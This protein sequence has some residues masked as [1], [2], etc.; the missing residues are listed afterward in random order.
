MTT[1]DDIRSLYRSGDTK[2]LVE[3]VSRQWRA[4]N[5]SLSAELVELAALAA[6]KEAQWPQAHE[7]LAWLCHQRDAARDAYH[8]GLVLDKLGRPAEAIAAFEKSAAAAQ[9]RV[10]AGLNMAQCLL[11]TQQAR[12]ALQVLERMPLTNTPQAVPMHTLL[13]AQALYALGRYQ[14]AAECAAAAVKTQPKPPVNVLTVLAAAWLK[15]G[16]VDEAVAIYRDILQ[17]RPNNLQ[18]RYNLAAALSNHT[19]ADALREAIEHA[20]Q[21]LETAPEHAQARHTLALS[22]AKLGEWPRVIEHGRHLLSRW[23]EEPRYI[24]TLATALSNMGQHVQALEVIEAG[25]R[26]CTH[27]PA[28]LYRQKGI[29][30]CRLGQFEQAESA[31]AQ[32]HG[33]DD[34][35]QRTLAYL[36]I[37]RLALGQREKVAEFYGH[38]QLVQ[39]LRLQPSAAFGGLASYHQ[40]L[41]EDIRHHSRL[42]LN[43]HGLA[44]R[45][46]YLTGD[47]LADR[48]TAIVEFERLLRQAID[49]YLAQL[50]D[51]D[52]HPMLKHKA[53]VLREGYTLNLWATWV[54]GDGF[55][56]KHIHEESWLSGAYYVTVPAVC[57]QTPDSAGYFE[58]GCIPDDIQLKRTAPRG[59][60]QPQPGTLVVF[61]SYLYHRTIPHETAEDRISIAFDLTPK[62][63]SHVL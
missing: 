1:Y 4:E 39:Q 40:Q 6:I 15:L 44:A 43:P 23:P 58:Y 42:R 28:M 50:P 35:D 54:K 19:H 7:W 27:P 12:A 47:L 2:R 8:L 31:L 57:A 36:A 13:K 48:T 20:H 33:L 62:S 55:I 22:H 10:P 24:E 18:H 41:A 56:D 37:A 61:P 34:R 21:V 16:K 59:L 49:H 46:G 30:H 51:D 60:I 32:A 29:F 38:G 5:Q 3:V 52:T 53:A 14:E 9:F 11:R 26:A 25:L 63:W 17:A 45:N